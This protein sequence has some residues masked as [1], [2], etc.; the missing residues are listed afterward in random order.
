MRGS[1]L[2][3]KA[4]QSREVRKFQG[5]SIEVIYRTA[6]PI[7]ESAGLHDVLAPGTTVKKD[8][9]CYERDVAVV[10]RDGTTIYTDVYRPEGAAGVPAIVAWSPY[11]KRAGYAGMNS[12]WACPRG[13][14]RR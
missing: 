2:S 11:G 10:L 14:I 13:R 3:T 5:E 6:K 1:R 4:E 7:G 9:I 8:G 12:C